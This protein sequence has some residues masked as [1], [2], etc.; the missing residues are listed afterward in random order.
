[1]LRW[2]TGIVAGVVAL[3]VVSAAQ[4]K[5]PTDWK[6]RMDTPGKVIE[7]GEPGPGEMHFVGMPPGWHISTG[8]GALLYHADHALKGNFAIEAEV[9]LFPG[10]SQEEYGVFMGG[11]NLEAG[12]SPVYT[13]FVARRDGRGAV[14]RQTG[15][16]PIVAWKLNQA[17]LP[18]PGKETVK[19]VF[20]V[21]VNPKDVVFTANGK[22][23]ATLARTEVSVEGLFGF[24]VGSGMN[25]HASRMDV[26]QKLAPVPV[27]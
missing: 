17:I 7:A 8:P 2:M 13:A 6:W 19:N 22:E 15:A 21:D 25:L 11:R 23:V 27:K 5:T 14:I 24:R 9:F 18:H 10:D 1:M 4:L 12:Q 26:T 3:G 16:A 20:R